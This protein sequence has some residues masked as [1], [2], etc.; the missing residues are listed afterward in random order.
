MNYFRY[1]LLGIEFESFTDHEPL[2]SIFGGKKKGNS[3]VERHRIKTQGFSYILKH[4]PGKDNPADFASRHPTSNN[5]KTGATCE[6]LDEDDELCISKI[7]TS[8][9]PDALTLPMIRDAT[10][11]DS[12]SQKLVSC[13]KKGYITDEDALKPFR[14]VFSE[15]TT[16]N[17]VILKGE[18]L[19]I[20]D[21]E[22]SPG[23]GSLQRWCV[24]LAHDG[25]QGETKTKQLIRS[26]GWML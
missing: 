26:K 14:K 5:Q 20:P 4:L 12:V 6:V 21:V 19:Y 7:I 22:I 11:N 13:L 24:D 23:A 9:L 3:R 1:H 8:D 17:G 2:L 15:L 16:T 18:K 25:H 10:S